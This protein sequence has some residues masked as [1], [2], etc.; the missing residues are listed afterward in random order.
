MFP[1]KFTIPT[2]LAVSATLGVV[3]VTGMLINE[4]VSNGA[5]EGLNAE[6]YRQQKLLEPLK[7]AQ[8]NIERAR[9]VVREVYLTRTLDAYNKAAPLVAQRVTTAHDILTQVAQAVSDPEGKERIT[10]MLEQLDLYTKALADLNETQRVLLGLQA[11]RIEV[12]SQWAPKLEAA[13][14]AAAALADA[15]EVET[16]LVRADSEFNESRAGAWQFA[17]TADAALL[18]RMTQLMRDASATLERAR[19]GHDSLA[20]PIAALAALVKEFQEVAASTNATFEQRA[21]MR[22]N[23]ALPAA[24]EVDKL[25][26]QAITTAARGRDAARAHSTEEVAWSGHVG[27]TVG[28]LVI[29]I[30]IGSAL[31]LMFNVARPVRRI[32]EVLL[33]LARGDKTITIPFTARGD[34]VGD[35]ARAA[36]TFKDNIVRIEQMENEQKEA[37]RQD[38]IRRKAEMAKVADDFEAAV[39]DVISGVSTSAAELESTA[40]MLTKTAEATQQLA[41]AVVDASSESSSHVQSFAAAMEELATSVTEVGRQVAHSSGIADEAVRQANATDTRMAAL[42]EAAQR[43]GDVVKLITAIAEQTNLLALNAT[44]EAARAGDA[45]KGFAVVAAEVKSLA[46]QTAKATEEIGTQITGM[47]AATNDSVAA[48]KEIGSTIGRISQIAAT[49]AA[50]VEEQNTATQEIARNV[51]NAAK[52]TSSVAAHIADVSRAAIDTSSASAQMLGSTRTL[53]SQGN[54]LRTEVTSFLGSVRAS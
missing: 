34:E 8:V 14:S 54:R 7:L 16:L 29:A 24:T 37:A 51:Q 3:L 5:I 9:T 15:G 4:Q 6:A 25:I 41:G 32:G 35:N 31:F 18:Q 2:K 42:L 1:F 47:Q 21:S 46:N 13:R 12:Q 22:A 30:L 48:I 43:I 26:D 44:I 39:G 36:Q 40:T 10:A 33:A 11:R 23:R 53:S 27:L 45:G 17:D 19:A 49:I 38:E 28:V 50:A 52:S 20:Q